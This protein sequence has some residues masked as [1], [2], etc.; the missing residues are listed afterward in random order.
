MKPTMMDSAVVK[1]AQTS[2]GGQGEQLLRRNRER[3]R[4]KRVRKVR[5]MQE[6]Q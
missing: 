1:Q 3:V 5:R 4:K 6:T 2:G